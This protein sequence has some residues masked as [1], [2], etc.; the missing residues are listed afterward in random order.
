M[1][2]SSRK[3]QM[4]LIYLIVYVSSIG[5]PIVLPVLPDIMQEFTITPL[6]MSLI[7]SI[8]ALPGMLVIPMYGF[9]SD[10]LGR[11]PLLLLGLLLCFVGS[12]V[13]YFAP[14]YNWLLFGRAL[15]GLSITPLEALANTLTSDL[16]DGEERMRM[17]TR[18]TVVQYF[19]IASVP[20]IISGLLLFGNWRLSFALAASLGLI[21]L[22]FCLPIKPEYKAAT[23]SMKVYRQHLCELLVSRR[24]LSLLSLRVMSAL[25]L[26][27]VVYV[28]F[29]LL[30]TER[31]PDSTHLI[32]PI[33]S[34]Y[35]VGMFF[36]SLI[37]SH[38][39]R[40]FGPVAPG[41]MGGTTLSLGMAL[42]VILSNAWTG[43]TAMVMVGV[44]TAVVNASTV[45]HVSLA[46]TPDTKGSIM[47]AYSTVFRAGQ[48]VAPILC[49]LYFQLVGSSWLFATAT[50]VSILFTTWATITFRYANIQEHQNTS[51]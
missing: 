34:F 51:R 11:R 20:I 12:M 27:G 18:V 1:D 41:F 24:V 36:G 29:P 33:Y 48:T 45:G 37:T 39:N 21:A 32:G 26:F 8:Y 22:L 23:E 6:E 31:L 2:F 17:V 46:T 47:S 25:L 7:I 44:G 49:G 28:H 43:A 19:G 4:A 42:L 3:A 16:F 13:C 30:F 50:L 14:S 15:Q 5:N 10:R 38:I 40:R 9:L 35:A